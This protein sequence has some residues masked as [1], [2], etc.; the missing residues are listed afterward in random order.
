[1]KRLEH[2]NEEEELTEE[3]KELAVYDDELLNNILNTP[4]STPKS[5]PKPANK[6]DDMEIQL[7]DDDEMDELFG[8]P[9]KQQDNKEERTTSQEVHEKHYVPENNQTITYGY[10]MNISNKNWLKEIS[11]E[12]VNKFDFKNY[13]FNEYIIGQGYVH[14]YFDFDDISN[15]EDTADAIEWLDS[16]TPLFG[17]YSLGGLT[18][19]ESLANAFGFR[20]V[21]KDKHYISMHAVFY[22]TAIDVNDLVRIMHH[23]TVKGFSMNGVNKFCDSAVYKIAMKENGKES[24]QLFRHVMSDKRVKVPPR[25]K[26]QTDDEYRQAVLAYDSGNRDNHGYIINGDTPDKQIVQVRGGERIIEEW[27]WSKYFWPKETIMEKKTK[28]I[29]QKRETKAKN[30]TLSKV[31]YDDKL[32]IFDEDE[33][34]DFLDHFSSDFDTFMVTLGPLY[35]SPYD[36]E[37]LQTVLEKWYSKEPHQHDVKETIQNILKQY[38]KKE[39]SNKWFFSLIK[40]FTEEERR[41]YL[42]KYVDKESIDFSVNINNS[43]LT[44][45]DFYQRYY[46]RSDFSKLISDLRGVIGICEGRWYIKRIKDKQYYIQELAR[47]KASEILSTYK[48]FN[49]NKNV[50]IYQLISKYS[51]WFLYRDVKLTK[52]STDDV[53]NVF[54]GFK[55]QEIITDDFTILQP[56]LTHIK[57]VICANNDEKYDYFMKWWANIFQEVTVKNGTMPIIHGSQ[58]SG[59]S[60]PVECFCEILGIFALANVDDLDK[61]FGKFNGLI[62]RHLV[63]NIN[64]PPEANEKFKYLG[65]IKSK[66]TQKK[67]IQETKGIDQIEIDS[68]A[69]YLMTTNNPNPIQEEKGNRRIIYYPTFN[70]Y[71]GDTEYFKQLCKP[72]Q[73]KKQGD[74]NPEY[75]GVLLHYMKTQI[76]ITDFNP[77]AL[78]MKI[79]NNTHTEHNEQLD[80]QY[81]S[82]NLVDKYVV[83][84]YEYFVYGMPLNE[85]VIP[86]YKSTGIAKA[87]QA[88]CNVK[89]LREKQMQEII[90]AHDDVYKMFHNAPAGRC[91]VYVLKSKE[92]I[93]DLYNII[94]YIQYNRRK[95]NE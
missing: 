61:V 14:P 89:R 86:G 21:E 92:E 45:E 31:E 1:M 16:L 10:T 19:S 60:F 18:T 72:I 23:T 58:G 65:K 55:Y 79:N 42:K 34:C 5:E 54:Q 73:P 13:G 87:L 12:G 8:K 25:E 41:D 39:N 28:E 32:I 6:L 52:E 15:E 44:I 24:R 51:D 2:T 83:D 68:W 3:Q 93:P 7:A 80:R 35:H 20:Y 9:N 59:K 66:L 56:F 95:D 37:F 91:T 74:Y 11:F 40:H 70:G 67:T 94:E 50:S 88:T 69:N 76:N 71:S 26:G 48:P 84:Y 38:Y 47:Q 62:G 43:T 27:E 29:K 82:L 75:M 78:I 17:D 90:L 22:Q 30:F 85:I 53:I 64:E 77:E 81:N 33:M 57:T 4:N 36:K 49:G 46:E 63:I